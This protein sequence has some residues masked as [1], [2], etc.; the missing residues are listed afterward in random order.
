MFKSKHP[1]SISRSG[2]IQIDPRPPVYTK[3]E[4]EMYPEHQSTENL[5]VVK[6]ERKKRMPVSKY[7]KK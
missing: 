4:I 1:N 2:V 7:Q 5:E 3:Q 6:P